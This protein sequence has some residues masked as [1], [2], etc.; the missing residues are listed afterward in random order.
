M[1]L[2]VL[3]DLL[4]DSLP[5]INLW[6]GITFTFLVVGFYK[7]SRML[8]LSDAGLL[9]APTISSKSGGGTFLQPL[10]QAYSLDQTA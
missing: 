7:P 8:R 2:L 9:T 3:H 6:L 4:N 5:I 1:L 10:L